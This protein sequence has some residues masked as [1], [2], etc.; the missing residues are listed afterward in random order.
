M[1]SYSNFRLEREKYGDFLE[2]PRLANEIRSLETSKMVGGA[3]DCE[4]DGTQDSI[5]WLKD[6][7]VNAEIVSIKKE[8]R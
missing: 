6:M 4:N 2:A 3:M 5:D 8:N 7:V 1:A